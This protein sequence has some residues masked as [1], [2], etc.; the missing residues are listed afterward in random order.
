MDEG[1][2][3][4]VLFLLTSRGNWLGGKKSCSCSLAPAIKCKLSILEIFLVGSRWREPK[5][6]RASQVLK[7]LCGKGSSLRT[8]CLQTKGLAC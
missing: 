8:K 4:G 1:Q 6:A 5:A 7:L 3:K 2:A